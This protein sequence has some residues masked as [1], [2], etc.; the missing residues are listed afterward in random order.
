MKK[1]FTLLLRG[2]YSLLVESET[3]AEARPEGVTDRDGTKVD[4]TLGPYTSSTSPPDR[5]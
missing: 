3:R 2:T 4:P 1:G 5:T